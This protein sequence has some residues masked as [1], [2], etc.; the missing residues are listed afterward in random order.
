VNQHEVSRDKRFLVT[1]TDGSLGPAVGIRTLWRSILRHRPEFQNEWQTVALY[2]SWAWPPT[3]ACAETLSDYR[4]LEIP[5]ARHVDPYAAKMV[6]ASFVSTLPGDAEILYLDYDHVCLAPFHPG[7]PFRDAVRV[8]SRV[9]TLRLADG[10]GTPVR[11]T[12][13]KILLAGRQIN[14]SLLHARCS[15]LRDATRSWEVAYEGLAGIADPRFHEEIAFFVS[16][17][18]AGIEVRPVAP[19]VQAEW[20]DAETDAQLFHYG[21]DSSE[22]LALKQALPVFAKTG[23]IPEECAAIVGQHVLGRRVLA[24]L[25]G[26]V[27]M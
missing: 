11:A 22:S 25:I 17:A 7:F 20:S 6:L 21:G 24:E 23:A 15:T 19:R 8:G 1:V 2:P 12:D 10:P 4:I 5:Q 16:A 9:G 14:T 3:N 27:A 13:L 26:T 18:K